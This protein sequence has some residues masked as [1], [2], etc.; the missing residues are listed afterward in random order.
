MFLTR[1]H[2]LS[3]SLTFVDGAGQRPRF[4]ATISRNASFTAST[5]PK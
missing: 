5:L 2:A 4:A 1:Y 3:A